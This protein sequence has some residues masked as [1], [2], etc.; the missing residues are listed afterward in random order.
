MN[1]LH[2]TSIKMLRLQTWGLSH[3][4][5]VIF[6]GHLRF[7]GLSWMRDCLQ[8]KVSQ[9]SLIQRSLLSLT[10]TAAESCRPFGL[11][12]F[13]SRQFAA[14]LTLE[15]L[16]INPLQS[17]YVGAYVWEFLQTLYPLFWSFF[18]VCWDIKDQRLCWGRADFLTFTFNINVYFP[19]SKQVSAT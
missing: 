7:R 16:Q 11:P 4:A 5:D 14:L 13:S 6:E 1:S 12:F 9:R 3:L 19:M 17:A 15:K 2:L 18:G 8:A 10:L